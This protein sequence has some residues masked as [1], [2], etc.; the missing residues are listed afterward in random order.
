MAQNITSLSMSDKKGAFWLFLIG[1][2]S[3]TQIKVGAKIGISEAVCCLV[4]PFLFLKNYIQYK[5]DGVILFFNLLLLWMVGAIISDLYNH[6]CIE[7]VIRGFTV[8]LTLF[9]VSVCVYHFLR[10]KPGNL[11]WIL[12]GIAVSSVL[13][14]FVFQ[15]GLAGDMAAEG[16]ISGALDRVMGYKLFWSNQ[17]KTWC[18]LPVSGWYLALPRLVLVPMLL[19]I[20]FANMS[21]GGRSAFAVSVFSLLIV[22]VGGRTVTSIKALKRYFPLI[23]LGC[24]LSAILLKV[25]YSYAAEHGYLNEVETIKYQKQTAN[26][27]GFMSLIKSGRGDFFIGLDAALDKP[28]VGH[29]SQAMDYHGYEKEF[30][31]RYGSDLERDIYMS[32][33]MQGYLRTIK[34]HSHIICYWMWH[35]VSALI[36]WLYLL[37]L[38]VVTFQ[39]R[40]HYIPEWFGYLALSIPAFAWDFFFSPLG[41]R[42]D[43]CVLYCAMLVLL[44][45]ERLQ[46]RGVICA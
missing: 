45:F 30:V 23:V 4:G 3:M 32:L 29:G 16:D 22:L 17:V 5:R 34:S 8:P 35:G 40:L 31:S 9:C 2:F 18:S 24:C 6:S 15:R 43:E 13:S 20:A 7:Q 37:W 41:L 38:L 14:I 26:G 12:M 21:A 42:V 46:K 33:E 36:F 11:K 27:T 10:K 39:K 25:G 28:I 19:L 44:R 1:M